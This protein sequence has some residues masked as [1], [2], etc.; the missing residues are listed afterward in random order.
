MIKNASKSTK[1]I[2]DNQ[3]IIVKSIYFDLLGG[4]WLYTWGS[5]YYGQLAQGTR[6]VVFT[7]ELVE[8]FMNVHLLV[9]SISAGAKHCA[10]ITKDDELYTWGSNTDN[11]LGR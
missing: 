3:L 2:I 8:Y 4:G 5:G 9:K 10:A 7:P 11:C 1:F 6:L